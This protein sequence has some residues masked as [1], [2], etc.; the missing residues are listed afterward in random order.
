[1]ILNNNSII[2]S[3]GILMRTGAFV[4]HSSAVAPPQQVLVT[5][6]AFCAQ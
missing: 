3:P 5:H 2:F 1:M 4:H 6:G